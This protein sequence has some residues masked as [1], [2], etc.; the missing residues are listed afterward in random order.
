MINEQRL[1]AEAK[2]NTDLKL[3]DHVQLNNSIDFGT[4]NRYRFAFRF[5]VQKQGP[6]ERNFT[7]EFRSLGP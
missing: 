7:V 2:T 5:Q 4:Q 1:E 6:D 3:V